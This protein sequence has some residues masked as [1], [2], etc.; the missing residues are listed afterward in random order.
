MEADA[1]FAEVDPAVLLRVVEQLDGHGLVRP[2]W[3]V[4]E[5]LPEPLVRR[6]ARIYRSDRRSPKTCIFGPDGRILDSLTAVYGLDLLAAMVTEFGLDAR[7]CLG[8]GWQAREFQRVLRA[9]LA[10]SAASDAATMEAN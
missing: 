9:H 5:G 7:E 10:R 6:H 1:R 8:R 2:E 4:A 3:L